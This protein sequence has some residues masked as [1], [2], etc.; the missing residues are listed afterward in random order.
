MKT[1]QK[2]LTELERRTRKATM[3]DN[4]LFYDSNIEN[5]DERV[6]TEFRRKYKWTGVVIMLPK[7]ER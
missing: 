2:R 4:I 1:L 6:A 3:P 5:D 7:V